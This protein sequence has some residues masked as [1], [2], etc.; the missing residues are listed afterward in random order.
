MR[1]NKKL[2]PGCD[3]IGTGPEGSASVRA[4]LLPIMLTAL[5]VPARAGSLEVL[6]YSGFL[7][8]WEISATVTSDSDQPK[9]NQPNEY[10]GPLTMKH[11]GLCTQDGPE[12]KTGDIRLRMSAPSELD[13]TLSVAD[14]KC[15]YHGRL[16]DFYSGTLNCPDRGGVPLKLWVK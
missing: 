8:E 4:L 2:E 13:A 5:T 1:R 9:E 10:A 16:A 15:S 14:I 6:G 3:N 11:I 12:E 7:G